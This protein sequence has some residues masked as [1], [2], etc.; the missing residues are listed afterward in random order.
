MLWCRYWQ[1]VCGQPGHTEYRI[2]YD[3]FEH[4]PPWVASRRP[5]WSDMT[6]VKTTAQWREDWQSASVVNYTTVTDSTI[7]QPGFDLH[8]QSWSLLN[9]FQTGQGPCRALL[10]KWG[11][12]KSLTSNCGQQQTMSDIV[13][14]CPLTKVRWRTTTTSRSWRWRSQVAAVHSDY[15][16]CKM[17]EKN[18]YDYQRPKEFTMTASDEW[19][20]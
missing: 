3:V 16:I 13:D 17:N 2:W 18:T 4:P 15:S 14:A 10:H 12:A 5:I 6:P 11:L 20:T 19:Q 7:W 9:R 8:R 1:L